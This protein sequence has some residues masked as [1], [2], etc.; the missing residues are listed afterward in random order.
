[1]SYAPKIAEMNES[2][3]YVFKTSKIFKI[4]EVKNI[5]GLAKVSDISE[6][7]ENPRNFVSKSQGFDQKLS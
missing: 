5:Y 2:D 3:P 4:D 6:N 7:P 1:M